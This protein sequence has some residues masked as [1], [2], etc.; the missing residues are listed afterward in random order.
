MIEEKTL[1]TMVIRV[2]FPS[3]PGPGRPEAAAFGR[4]HL[5]RLGR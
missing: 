5:D 4:S 3:A 2:D 1:P